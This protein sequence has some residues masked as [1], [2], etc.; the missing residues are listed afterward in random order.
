MKAIALFGRWTPRI[1][2]QILRKW[3]E[4]IENQKITL[5]VEEGFLEAWQKAEGEALPLRSFSERSEIMEVAMAF[6]IG[7]D[8][9]FLEAARVVAPIGVPLLGVHGGRL[10][11]LTDVS[12]Q[13]LISATEALLSGHYSI[14]KRSLISIVTDPEV[15]RPEEAFALN[16][17]VFSKALTG[18]MILLDVYL[19]GELV[20]TYW[21]DGL[22][23][24]TPTGSTAYSL[25][26]GG[27]ILTPNCANLI[28]TPIAPHSLTVRALVLPDSGVLTVTFRS[29]TGQVQIAL[30]GRSVTV[31]DQ[32]AVAL[33][34]AP[35]AL[36]IIKLAGHSYFETLRD[37]LSW[38]VDRRDGF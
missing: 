21:A 36:K 33:R 6:V 22:I 32:T 24:S 20:N 15:F 38:G 9:S 4:F 17:V 14:E 29:R 34:R 37:R 10:G 16:E 25:A 12:Q 13:Q 27:P 31:P 7:G 19:N 28:L 2:P 30:D 23:V 11:F 26:C 3:V 8:G 1:D 18:E 35:I 5:W